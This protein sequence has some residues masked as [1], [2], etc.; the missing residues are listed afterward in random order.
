MIIEVNGDVIKVESIIKVTKIKPPAFEPLIR[1]FSVH[2]NNNTF[3]EIMKPQDQEAELEE[4]R[5]KI[6]QIWNDTAN[7][8]NEIIK[9]D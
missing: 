2:V 6:I 3:T 8:G 9:L 4:I 7:F 5:Q 1:K